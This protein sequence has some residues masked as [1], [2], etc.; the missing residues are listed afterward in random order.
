MRR[1][2]DIILQIFAVVWQIQHSS[3]IYALALI[4]Q[5]VNTELN[6]RIASE[7]R[8]F[9]QSSYLFEPLSTICMLMMPQYSSMYSI[10]IFSVIAIYLFIVLF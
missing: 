5:I 8:L 2:H 10:V 9:N 4:K 7:S 1:A 3:H 6:V